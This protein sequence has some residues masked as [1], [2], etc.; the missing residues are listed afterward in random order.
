MSVDGLPE[1]SGV[2][3]VVQPAS[4]TV[5]AG[6]AD[7]AV[8]SRSGSARSRPVRSAR[9]RRFRRCPGIRCPPSPP[10]PPTAVFT[11]I[12]V[13]E[14]ESLAPGE[15]KM[16]PPRPEPPPPPPPP[17]PPIPPWPFGAGRADRPAA[18]TAHTAVAAVATESQI[19]ADDAVRD[20]Q[21]ARG[22]ENTA[23]FGHASACAAGAVAPTVPPPDPSA[24][25]AR[26]PP[27]ANCSMIARRRA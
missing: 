1:K 4:E 5:S 21:R 16:P 6:A 18:K 27:T 17:L 13:P 15:L 10:S 2:P 3:E 23:A 9:L 26:N 14:I 11:E 24:P 7:A 20:G 25:F 19:G 12:V 8:P 22:I